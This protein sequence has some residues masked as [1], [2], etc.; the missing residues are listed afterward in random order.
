MFETSWQDVVLLIG[1]VI[2]CIALIPSILGPHKPS[3]WTS[4]ITALTLTA[5]TFT[6]ISLSLTYATVAVG[7]STLGWWILYFQKR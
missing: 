4:L 3:K 7:I 1:N 5:F 6:Y 2:Y